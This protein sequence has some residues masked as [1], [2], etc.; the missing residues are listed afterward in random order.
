MRVIFFTRIIFWEK[1]MAINRQ[2]FESE[3]SRIF[4]INGLGSLLDKKKTETFYLLTERMLT[5]NEKYNLTAITEPEKIILNHYADCAT[6]AEKLPKGAKIIDVGCGAGFPSLPLAIVREDISV[7]AMDSAAKRVNY[8]GE[9]CRLLGINN[10]TAIV[11]R[12]EDAAKLP[13]YREKFD[14]ATARAVAEL[15]VLTE[16]CL[17]FVKVGGQMLSM[18]GKNAEFELSG[19]KK[20]IAILGG[21]SAKLETVTLKG[22]REELTHPIISVKKKAKTPP[23]YPRA[24]AQISKKPL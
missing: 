4:K 7:V 17:P 10:L 3:L 6:L 8:V 20:A 23:A 9:T 13:E 11:S 2:A 21:E 14:F 16:L 22:G 19:A 1:Y 18:K 24:Y 12:A 15:R 5:E